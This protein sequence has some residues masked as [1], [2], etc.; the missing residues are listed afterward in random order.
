MPELPGQIT[1]SELSEGIRV[2]GLP[3]AMESWKQVSAASRN[4]CPAKSLRFEL[5]QLTPV[6]ARLP[7]VIEESAVVLSKHVDDPLPC[8]LVPVCIKRDMI[9]TQRSYQANAR[10]MNTADETLAELVQLV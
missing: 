10:V 1:A 2:E 3:V 7:E 6:V 8:F 5:K 4:C 9:S